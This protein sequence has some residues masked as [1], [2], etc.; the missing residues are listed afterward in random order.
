MLR[1]RGCDQSDFFHPR[2]GGEHVKDGRACERCNSP[3]A[4][5]ENK[6]G[7]LPVGCQDSWERCHGFY[8]PHILSFT[9]LSREN[10]VSLPATLFPQTNLFY[11]STL[12]LFFLPSFLPSS[13]SHLLYSPL[14]ILVVIVYIYRGHVKDIQSH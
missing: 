3:R 11:S 6:V 4:I 14:L 2:F 8:L 5:P 12:L 9:C 1:A 10:L 7:C 13:P